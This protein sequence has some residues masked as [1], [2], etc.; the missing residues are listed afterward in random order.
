MACFLGLALFFSAAPALLPVLGE[1][2]WLLERDAD[3]TVLMDA[4]PSPWP[5]V[6]PLML[7]LGVAATLESHPRLRAFTPHVTQ[8]RF[9]LA[10]SE[11]HRQQ[12]RARS[13]PWR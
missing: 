2:S 12:M 5:R 4:P 13:G 7:L 1:V 10:T 6:T 8:N 9:S 11:R 3:P